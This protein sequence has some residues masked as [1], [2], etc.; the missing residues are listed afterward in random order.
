MNCSTSIVPAG[1]RALA[2]LCLLVALGGCGPG[3]VGTGSGREGEGGKDPAFTPLDL[4]TAAFEASGLACQ[5]DTGNRSGGTAPVSW[6]DANKSNEGAAVL[7]ALEGN[8][9]SLQIPCANVSFEGNWGELDDGRLAFVGRYAVPG[10][11]D[12]GLPGL[13]LVEPEPDEPAAV[14]QLRLEDGTGA[15]LFDPWLVRRVEGP[16]GFADCPQ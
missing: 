16:V 11:P 9:I 2:A 1:L 13:V 15:I 14:G 10:L 6:S 7:A 12:S 8:T 4:C 3:V 5:S